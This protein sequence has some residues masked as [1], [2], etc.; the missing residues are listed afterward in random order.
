M[1]TAF[2]EDLIEPEGALLI[3]MIIIQALHVT[4]N[5]EIWIV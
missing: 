3:I 5:G 2:A 1:P 4:V